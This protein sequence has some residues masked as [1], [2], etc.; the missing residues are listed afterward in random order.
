MIKK[1]FVDT[2]ILSSSNEE[3]SSTADEMNIDPPMINI[4][5][6]MCC[7]KSLPESLQKHHLTVGEVN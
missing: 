1:S 7:S 4:D 3:V 2:Q 5:L 6:Q